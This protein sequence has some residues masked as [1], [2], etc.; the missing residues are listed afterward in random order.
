MIKRSKHE[1]TARTYELKDEFMEHPTGKS[2]TIPDDSYTIAELL[3]KFQA[4]IPLN[5]RQGYFDENEEGDEAD[6]DNVDLEKFSTLDISE[7]AELLAEARENIMSDRE[8][9]LAEKQAADQ[10]AYDAKIQAEA[11]EILR[12]REEE[13]GEEKGN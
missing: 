9:K 1:H 8:K 5:Q 12:K 7:Q 6:H 4:G 2:E 13:K 10:A 3:A 11:L